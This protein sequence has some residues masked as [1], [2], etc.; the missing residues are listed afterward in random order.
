MERSGREPSAE[1]Q[2]LAAPEALRES[3]RLGAGFSNAS[4]IGFVH[5]RCPTAYAAL[6]DALAAING[7]PAEAHLGGSVREVLGKIAG[8]AEQHRSNLDGRGFCHDSY[9]SPASVRLSN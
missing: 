4:P 8:K 9:L 1:E 5:P 6:N 2:Y 7:V 3:Q